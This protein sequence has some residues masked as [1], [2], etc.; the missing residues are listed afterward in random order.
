MNELDLTRMKSEIE[1]ELWSLRRKLED[2]QHE[3]YSIQRDIKELERGRDQ[4]YSA[5]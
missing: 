3:I 5:S 2:L 1:N 4:S